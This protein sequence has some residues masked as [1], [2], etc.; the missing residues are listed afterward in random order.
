MN[1]V[2]NIISTMENAP[3]GVNLDRVVNFVE[4]LYNAFDGN[5]KYNNIDELYEDPKLA[6]AQ[7][8][9]NIGWAWIQL[10]KV[11]QHIKYYIDNIKGCD[12]NWF[13]NDVNTQFMVNLHDDYFMSGLIDDQTYYKDMIENQDLQSIN[14]VFLSILRYHTW[15]TENV[16]TI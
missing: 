3:T 5:A 4:I 15:L 7:I 11:Y 1:N 6:K 14:S 9:V 16:E 2:K 10:H 8:G 12:Y 13:I